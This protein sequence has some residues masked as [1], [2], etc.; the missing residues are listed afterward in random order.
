MKAILKNDSLENFNLCIAKKIKILRL[1]KGYSLIDFA[2]ILGVS[3]QQIQKY[4]NGSNAL[5]LQKVYALSRAFNVPTSY[6]FPDDHYNL[7]PIHHNENRIGDNELLET[8]KSYSK[9]KHCKIRNQILQLMKSLDDKI[10]N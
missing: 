7:Q 2:K 9:I 10:L 5:S 4:E 1:K 8:V 6:F 3:F